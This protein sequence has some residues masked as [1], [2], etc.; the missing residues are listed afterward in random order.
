MAER[1]ALDLVV[2]DFETTGLAPD[3][4]DRAIEVGAVRLR[5]GQ[6]VDRFQGL[7]NPGFAVS[8]FIESFTG[9]SNAMLAD[10]PP[11]G[12][13][14][15]DFADFLGDDNL[16]AHNAAFDRRFLDAELAAL[17]RPYAGDFVCS[18]LVARRF[19]QQA[20][21]H[22]LG[23]LVHYKGLAHDGV[24]HRALADAEMT[25]S[26]WR[27]MVAEMQQQSGVRSLR[28]ADL[29]RFS[30]TPKAKAQAFLGAL[31]NA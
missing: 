4:G 8:G 17:G 25:A 16:V 1:P 2:L 30:Q 3:R 13:V 18:L 27:T 14:M 29:K 12:R 26:L 23:T 21:N 22:K 11:C 5:Q 15:S 9:I 28:F 10:A 6:V 7:M 19:Y 31:A 24:F 20:P